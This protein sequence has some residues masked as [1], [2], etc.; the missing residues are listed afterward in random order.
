MQYDPDGLERLRLA[1]VTQAVRDYKE[2]LKKLKKRPDNVD[3]K[4]KKRQI[5]ADF[6]SQYFCILAGI[7][8][9]DEFASLIRSNMDVKSR[10][11]CTRVLKKRYERKENW[12]D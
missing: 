6:R 7:D 2:V 5:E 4:A 10:P 1:V 11:E 3:L 8:D 12:D 9:G